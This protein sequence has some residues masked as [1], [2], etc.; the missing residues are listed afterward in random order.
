MD[1]VCSTCWASSPF[2]RKLELEYGHVADVEYRLGGLLKSWKDYEDTHKDHI[3]A[4]E[5]KNLWNYTGATSG[6]SM[7]GNLWKTNPLESS[8]PV[9]FAFYAVRA[10]KPEKALRFLRILQE[11]TFLYQADAS[12]LTV[13]KKVV[14][15]LNIDEVAFL[16]YLNS[17]ECVDQFNNDLLF[18]QEEK[19]KNFPTIYITDGK[20]KTILN[21]DTQYNDWKTA[22]ESFIPDVVPQKFEGNEV[23]V[24]NRYPYLSTF[25]IAVILDKS[26]LEVFEELKKYAKEEIIEGDDYK[27]GKFWKLKAKNLMNH[28]EVHDISEVT[29][30]GGG[31]AGLCAGINLKQ[32]GIN[33][34][35]FERRSEGNNCGLGFVI[36]NNGLKVLDELGLKEKFIKAG[37][38]I[39]TFK[40][41]HSEERSYSNVNFEPVLSITRKAA[42][43]ILEAAYG[44]ENIIYNKS[45]HRFI[46]GI[47]EQYNLV[48][49]NDGSVV[50]SNTILACDGINSLAR[51]TLFPKAQLELIGECEIVGITYNPLL[52]KQLKTTFHK[53]VDSRNGVNM[54][55]LPA[56]DGQV[57][58]FVQIDTN[59]NRRPDRDEDLLTLVKTYSSQLPSIYQRAIVTTNSEN[60]YL[61]N[62]YDMES[63]PAF[64]KDGLFLLGDAAHPLLSFTSQ[65]V[66]TALEDAFHITNQE[67]IGQRHS[68][69]ESLGKD[70]YAYRID[71]IEKTREEGLR[72]LKEFLYPEKDQKTSIPLVFTMSK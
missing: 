16:R 6:M 51:K 35:I 45:V 44:Q 19:I 54:G 15:H 10:L 65:G 20:K 56:G 17:K 9:T 1:P 29:I 8:Y 39:D 25:E 59:R 57:I 41:L 30:I 3:T 55:V 60:V 37:V 33:S 18:R 49:F 43:E 58:W 31:L 5:L 63:L 46:K 70:Y 47:S 64:E 72:L 36:M 68:D 32:K 24:L 11:L 2:F 42:V 71:T 21:H 22:I 53:H 13:Q 12:S 7:D 48:E 66:S 62:I 38:L 4:E 52:N 67:G 34:L 14:K 69:K 27:Y 26:E 23:D 28:T 50:S 40:V 61:W